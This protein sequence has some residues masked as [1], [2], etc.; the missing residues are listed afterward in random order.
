MTAEEKPT[1]LASIIIPHYAGEGILCRCL[2]KIIANTRECPYEIILVDNGSIDGSVETASERFPD[3]RVLRYPENNGFAIACNRGIE[4]ARGKYVILLNDDTEVGDNWL[5]PVI[6]VMES[7]ES[8]GACQP[9]VR[10]LERPELFEYSGAAGGMIDIF[11]FPFAKGRIFDDLEED[12]GQYDEPTRAFWAS[13]T[14][15]FLR[16]SALDE[17]GLLDEF[18]KCYM[19]EIDLCWRLHLLGYKVVYVPHS[20]VYHKGGHTLVHTSIKGGKRIRANDPLAEQKSG[21]G[22]SKL[23]LLTYMYYNHR[24]SLIMLLKNLSLRHLIWIFPIRLCLEL[25][26]IAG[27]AIRNR[28]RMLAEIMALSYLISHV[29]TIIGKRREVQ[30]L[31]RRPDSDVLSYQYWGLVTMEYFLLGRKKATELRSYQ[32]M[33][34]RLKLPVA[35]DKPAK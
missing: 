33:M 19:E 30:R 25:T 13:G 10:S 24:N 18:F 7:D 34:E 28:R 3:V 15:I 11:G 35:G 17:S 27:A 32:K 8:I 9:K 4:A 22:D 21:A 20:I 5:A 16:K 12:R 14:A 26:V 31:R 1:P 23:I 29:P 2:E 6:S